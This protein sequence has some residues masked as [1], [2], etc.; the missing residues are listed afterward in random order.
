MVVVGAH[1]SLQDRSHP[2]VKPEGMLWP[3]MR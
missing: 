3:I 2:R 1:F